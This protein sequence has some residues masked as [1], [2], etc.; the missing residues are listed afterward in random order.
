MPK[1]YNSLI[2]QLLLLGYSQLFEVKVS[3]IDATEHPEQQVRVSVKLRTIEEFLM[4]QSIEK[5]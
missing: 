3:Q 5:K 4:T 1:E 2:S